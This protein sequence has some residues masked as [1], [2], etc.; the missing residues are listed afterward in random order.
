VIADLDLEVLRRN[1]LDGTVR[2][3]RDRRL[4]LYDVIEKTPTEAAATVKGP[5]TADHAV[6]G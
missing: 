1:R 3:W 4:D 2:C 5:V 6:L